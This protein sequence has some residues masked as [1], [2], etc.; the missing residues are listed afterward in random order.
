MTLCESVADSAENLLPRSCHGGSGA[1]GHADGCVNLLGGGARVAGSCRPCLGWLQRQ[2]G[3]GWAGER[4]H[5]PG[6]QSKQTSLLVLPSSKHQ[7]TAEGGVEWERLRVKVP[8]VDKGE[9]KWGKGGI[10][11]C[12]CDQGFMSL[13][14]R[15]LVKG[16]LSPWSPG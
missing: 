11:S 2:G 6:C 8:G 16:S 13:G 5:G 7:L 15:S 3:V 10:S 14:E 9:C 1:G 12:F 4:E